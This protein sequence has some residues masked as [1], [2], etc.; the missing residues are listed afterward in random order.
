MQTNADQLENHEEQWTAVAAAA[1]DQPDS[2]ACTT[3][4]TKTL[5][6]TVRLI[7]ADSVEEKQI[8]VLYS[9]DL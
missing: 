9:S 8:K 1:Q 4:D 7:D 2:A 5:A 3:D 6:V